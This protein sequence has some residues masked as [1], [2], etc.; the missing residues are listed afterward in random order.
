[1][2]LDSVNRGPHRQ[3]GTF[4]AWLCTACIEPLAWQHDRCYTCLT[5]TCPKKD[6]AVLMPLLMH[7][8]IN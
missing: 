2:S 1:M 4:S 8:G 6:T 3:N 7:G 5:P